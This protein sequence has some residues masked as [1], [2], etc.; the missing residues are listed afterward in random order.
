VLTVTTTKLLLLGAL[1][2]AIG[3]TLAGQT[4]V[5]SSATSTP[6]SIQDDARLAKLPPGLREKGRQI[7]AAADED[8][9]ADLAEALADQHAIDALDFLLTLLDTDPSA[10]VRENIVDELESVDDPRVDPAL[11]RRVL[12]DPDLDLALAS[13]ELMR[14]RAEAPLMRLLERRLT[15]ERKS[16]SADAVTRLAAEQE[17]WATIV[18]G[19][20][21]PTFFQKPPAL[22]FLKPQGSPLRVLAFG[23]F[24]D[25]S[26]PQKRVAAAML[27][28]HDRQPF[29]FAITL[30]DN[31]YPRGME[32]PSDPRWETW[33]SALYD[34]LKIQFYA[35]FGNHDW[36]QPNSPAAEILFSERSPSWR[37]PA[38]YYTF[39]AGPVQFF[40]LDTDIISA[41][42]LRWLTEALDRSQAT[43]KVVYGHHPIYSAGDHEDNEEL[44]AQ[45]LPVLK[46][47]ADIYLAGHDHDMQHLKPEG[48]LHF[49]VA[50]TGG[51]LRPITPGPRSLFAR[52]ARGFAVLDA[53]AATLTVKFVEEDLTSAYTY[54]LTRSQPAGPAREF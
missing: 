6:T 3:P 1:T 44:I 12:V 14:A 45:L 29:D 35:S 27:R 15:A 36:N 10:D 18:R 48:R 11:E 5:P 40:A 21:L 53:D 31:F 19:G 37:M 39:E 38:A 8:M 17:R 13:L 9:R 33:W 51:K 28:Y 54:T 20:L 52:S 26:D 49:F 34:P 46:D 23:D 22:F 50:G 43:W 4:P 41:A 7:L 24:G 16:G 30:G 32:S 42:Q 25:G 2:L 47:R